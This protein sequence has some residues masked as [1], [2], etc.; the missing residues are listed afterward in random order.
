MAFGVRIEAGETVLTRS[1]SAQ[2]LAWAAGLGLAVAAASYLV[3]GSGVDHTEGAL[4]VVIST[5]LLLG[6]ALVLLLAPG[7]AALLRWTLWLLA[8]ADVLGTGLAATLLH[9]WALLALMAVALLAGL[10]WARPAP[11]RAA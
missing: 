7:A 11:E 10:A 1:S 5:A 9:A 8:G 2:V 6:A 3:R 4:L